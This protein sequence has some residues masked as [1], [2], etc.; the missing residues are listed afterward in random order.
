MN[1]KLKIRPY[2]ITDYEQV[3]IIFEESDSFD[4][5]MD[6]S[7]R[8][9]NKIK[10]DPKS[11]LVAEIN[12]QVIGNVYIINDEWFAGIFRLGVRKKYRGNDI[13]FALLQKAES[14]LKNQGHSQ[15][16]IFVNN[17]Y[18]RLINWY[19]NHGYEHTDNNFKALW[20]EL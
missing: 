14:Y 7:E 4:P 16:M 18:D 12:D 3:K 1:D 5:L 20:K 19:K 17:K 9:E 2:K 13:G 6:T 10:K 15:V 8:L 11:I